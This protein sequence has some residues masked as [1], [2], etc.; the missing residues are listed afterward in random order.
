MKRTTWPL[1]KIEAKLNAEYANELKI[2][3]ALPKEKQDDTDPQCENAFDFWMLPLRP[4]KKF[5][6]ITTTG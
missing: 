2:F 5:I 3:N 6:K 1:K 4:R